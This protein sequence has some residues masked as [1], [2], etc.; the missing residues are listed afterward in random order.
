MVTMENIIFT[1]RTETSKTEFF[2]TLVAHLQVQCLEMF[3]LVY[4]KQWQWILW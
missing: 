2:Q 1:F 3:Y 4:K